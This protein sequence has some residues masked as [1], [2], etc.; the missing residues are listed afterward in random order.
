[1]GFPPE[2]LL[3]L[4]PALLQLRE[5]SEAWIGRVGFATALFMIQVCAA[6]WAQPP[7]IALAY[8][9]HRQ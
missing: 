6:A 5:G 3:F 4:E 2:N 8:D 9:F 7:A 1:M